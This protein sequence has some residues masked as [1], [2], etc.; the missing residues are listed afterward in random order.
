MDIYQIRPELKKPYD[1]LGNHPH[2][3]PSAGIFDE[4]TVKTCINAEWLSHLTG[5]IER[6]DY[7]DA[8]QGTEQEIYD[9]REAVRKIIAAFDTAE[10]GRC[11]LDGFIVGEVRQFAFATL[12]SMWLACDGAAVSRTTYADLFAAL[13][14]TFGVGNGTTTF[15]LPD[16]RSRLVIST[17]TGTARQNRFIADT[18][19]EERVQ[20]ALSEI[21][22]HT[23]T[24]VVTPTAG[25]AGTARV[26]ANHDA[27]GSQFSTGSAGGGS[28]HENMPPFIALKFGIFAGV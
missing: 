2:A 1:T 22:A 26:L 15:N 11:L 7:D 19:G 5:M 6:L 21:P 24:T 20:L 25:A 9:A 18:G 8:W 27:T 23:H 13:G 28:N 10:Q 16:L 4:P 17:G 12:P 14:T 3:I